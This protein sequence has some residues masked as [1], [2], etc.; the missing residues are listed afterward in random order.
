MTTFN[1]A[2]VYGINEFSEFTFE[3]FGDA[4]KLHIGNFIQDIHTAVIKVKSITKAIHNK[5]LGHY[6]SE[7]EREKMFRETTYQ[8][9]E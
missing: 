7:E 8:I 5:I 3:H 1:L 6:V 9:A 4:V 2:D